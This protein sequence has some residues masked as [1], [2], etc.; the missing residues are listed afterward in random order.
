LT[1]AAACGSGPTGP[2]AAPAEPARTRVVAPSLPIDAGVADATEPAKLACDPGAV[3][4]AA[5]AP[6]PTWFCMR[7]NARNGAFVTLFP[8]GAVEI[9]GG[10]KDGKLD[11]AWQRVFPGG[12]LAE[13][14]T[15]TGGEKDGTWKQLG[16][17]PCSA[18]TR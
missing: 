1:L 4:T 12:A 14:G 13:A 6:E 7:D 11:G 5:P 18:S 3:A 15:Y 8:D 10:Y 9:R 2:N 16:P 17:T